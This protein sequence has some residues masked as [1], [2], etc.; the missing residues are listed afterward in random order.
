M[1]RDCLPVLALTLFVFVLLPL[2][3]VRRWVS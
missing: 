3:L 1:N 2:A